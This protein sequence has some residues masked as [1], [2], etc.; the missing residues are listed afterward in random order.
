MVEYSIGVCYGIIISDEKL[1]SINELFPN[2]DVVDDFS[3]NYL[4]EVN[5]WTGGDWFLGVYRDFSGNVINTSK[6]LW[7][8]DE[9]LKELENKLRKYKIIDAIDWNPQKYIIQFC[10]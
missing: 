5:S 4:R 7:Y 3:D 8:N 10:Y 6:I 9:A 2:D 1:M